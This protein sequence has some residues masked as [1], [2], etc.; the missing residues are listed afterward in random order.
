MNLSLAT[1]CQ[2]VNGTLLTGNSE[3]N[4]NDIETDS[5]KL[6]ADSLFFA[7]KGEN[8]DG[9]DYVAQA[10]RAG[11]LAAVISRN[12]DVLPFEYQDR[13]L[14]LVENTMQALQALAGYYRQLFDIP[15]IAVTGSVG[16]TTTKELIY[17]CLSSR[18][19]TMKTEANFNN[20]I[21]L[22]LT[23]FKMESGHQAAVLEMAMRGQG[24]ILR[25]ADI[26]RPTCSVITNVEG[27]HLE[28]LGSVE[29]IADAKCEI[30]AFL[31]E[32]HYALINGDNEILLKA[33]SRYPCCLY[34]FGFNDNCDFKIDKLTSD[35]R[36]M[37]IDMRLK[38]ERA[39]FHFPI[40]SERL[41]ANIAACVG[42]SFLMGIDIDS[43]QS[44]LEAYKPSGNRLNITRFPEGG[45]L[46]ND[47]YNAN[48]LSMTAALETGRKIAGDGKLV[49][50]LGDM[51]ELGAHEVEGHLLVGRKASELDLD[52][53]VAV[54]SLAKHI[55]AGAVEAGMAAEK[56]HYFEEKSKSI[57]FLQQIFDKNDTIIFKASH[58]M[59][60]ETLVDELFT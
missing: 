45:S 57:K 14:I 54:G 35:T 30:L 4:I 34:T 6:S 51:F 56:V 28:T 21:G 37:Q 11:A 32:Q 1:I 41:A 26:A 5:R 12:I 15:V 10:F 18:F 16:K 52:T 7:L 47:T 13:A 22:P 44:G 17:S 8:F 38:G 40:P 31:K 20:D 49:A 53:L 27:V 50:V 25:L 46:I 24:E 3:L 39:R 2:H 36:G 33:A 43:I 23:I 42:V 55:A 58:G 60:L 29:N 59:H 48:P 19:K 9:H